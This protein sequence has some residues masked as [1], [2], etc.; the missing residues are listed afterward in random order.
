MTSISQDSDKEKVRSVSVDLNHDA[1]LLIDIPDALCERDKVKFTVHTKTTLSSF[2]KPEFS[3]PRQHEDFIWLHDTIVETE[4]YAGLIIPPAPPKPDFEGPREKMHKLGEGESSMTKEEYAKMKQE[5][6]AEYLAVFKKTVQVHE[7]FLQRLSSHPVF[8][9]DRNFQIF[10]EYDQDLT[11]RRKNAKEM[12][13]GF[14]KNMVKTADEVLISGVKEVDEFFEQEKTFLLDYSVK[15]KDSAAKAEK[16]TRSHKNVADDYNHISGALNSTAADN[17]SAFKKHL[18]KCADVFEKL[19][20]VED[21]VASDQELKLTE[22][23][24]YYTRDIQAAKD[25]LYRRA[26]ALADYENSNKALDKARL[27]GKDIAQAEENQKQCLQKFDKLSES[28]RKELTS[29]KA[30]RVIAFRK[31]LI[32]MTELEIKHAKN[33]V[34][35]LQ[36]SIEMLKGN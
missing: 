9:K 2:Q 28:G 34:S 26:R 31:N 14:F 1:S 20:K 13:G 10:L 30:R 18:E 8:S 33:S 32:E 36:G 16:M 3:V 29:F 27:K 21:R 22:L 12:F 23:L 6:E 24:R 7:V 15:I 19:R 35:L 11:V 5:L 25:L 4:D 17:N